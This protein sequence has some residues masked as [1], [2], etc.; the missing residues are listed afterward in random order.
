MRKITRKKL[1]T[2]PGWRVSCNG[3]SSDELAELRKIDSLVSLAVSRAVSVPLAEV[4]GEFRLQELSLDK[5]QIAPENL[6]GA[7]SQSSLEKLTLHG[8]EVTP[9][10]LGAIPESL[11]ALV[12]SGCRVDM[13]GLPSLARL[14]NLDELTLSLASFHG[15]VDG[16]IQL[17]SVRIV[18]FSGSNL[19]D[20]I[21][22]SFRFG[23][24]LESVSVMYTQVYPQT[25]ESFRSHYD[26]ADVWYEEVC[27][28]EG[29]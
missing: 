24:R 18:D 16:P 11:L 17:D 23:S 12:L 9:Q 19:T 5:C 6:I 21:L 8:M 10:Q 25:V 3:L 4:I 14:E 7:L 26:F 20:A 13:E 27:A 1:V 28:E 29:R 2:R 22:S 15:A